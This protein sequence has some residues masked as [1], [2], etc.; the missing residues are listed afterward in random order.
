MGLDLATFRSLP[1]REQLLLVK[2][3]K[4]QIYEPGGSY[5]MAQR[6]RFRERVR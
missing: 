6:R 1:V 5:P 2:S 3:P 4:L